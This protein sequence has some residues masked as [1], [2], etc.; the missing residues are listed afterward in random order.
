M[1][2]VLEYLRFKSPFFRDWLFWF[3]ILVVLAEILIVVIDGRT[4]LNQPYV[5]IIGIATTVLYVSVS[6]IRKVRDEDQIMTR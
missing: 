5:R 6:V 1:P 2:S 4:S 3:L